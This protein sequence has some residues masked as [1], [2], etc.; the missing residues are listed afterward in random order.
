MH[1]LAGPNRRTRTGINHFAE[2]R[3]MTPFRVN[4]RGTYSHGVAIKVT[5]HQQEQQQQQQQQ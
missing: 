4:P 3:G 2:L 5:T 1:F